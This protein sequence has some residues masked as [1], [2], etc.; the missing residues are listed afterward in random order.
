MSSVTIRWVLYAYN[1]T[2]NG[3]KI[4]RGKVELSSIGPSSWLHLQVVERL[5]EHI[6][7]L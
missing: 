2:S 6:E 3:L 4:V 1:R 5:T 7:G